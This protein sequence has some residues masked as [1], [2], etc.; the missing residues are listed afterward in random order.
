MRI[1]NNQSNINSGYTGQTLRFRC[2]RYSHIAFIE[3]QYSRAPTFSPTENRII[4]V[5]YYR[6]VRAVRLSTGDRTVCR[7]PLSSIRP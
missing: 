2:T 4:L 1:R 5:L 6:P 7:G 3:N